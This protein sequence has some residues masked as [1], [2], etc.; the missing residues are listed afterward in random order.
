MEKNT[1]K[2]P[3]PMSICGLQT[4]DETW[5]SSG[6]KAPLFEGLGVLSFPISTK[7]DLAQK[8][9][10]QGLILAYGFNFGEAARSFYYASQLDPDC[11]MC[12]WGYAFV[13]GPNYN[14]R[15][16]A[17]NNEKAFDAV[18]KALELSDKG[19]EKERALINALANRYTK[20]FSEK[21]LELDQGYATAKMK[22]FMRFPHDPDIGTLYADALMNIHPWDLWEKNG[23]PKK[24]TL[25]ILKVL[26]TAIKNSPMHPGAHHLYIHAVEAS[27]NPEIGLESARILDEGIVPAAG[28]LVHMP[29]HIYIHVGEYHKGTLANIKAVA[30]DSAYV[31]NCHAQGVY[32][33]TYY[34]H[35]YHFMAATAT[36]EGN[37]HWAILAAQKVSELT[38]FEIMKQKEWTTLQHYFVI[39][40]YVYVKLGKWDMILQRDQPLDTLT[41]PSA[42]KHYARGLA[43]LGK[44][45][46]KK[47]E[48]ELEKLDKLM[49]LKELK[50]LK[51]WENNSIYS[52]VEIAQRVLRGELFA[53]QNKFT[54]AIIQLKKAVQIE[55]QLSYSEPPDWFFSV[56]HH[57]GAVQIE[58]EKYEDAIQTLEEDLKNFPKNGWALHGLRLAYKNLGE[59]EKAKEMEDKLSMIWSTADIQISSSRIK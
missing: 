56:R 34:P 31:T 4:T 21:R 36:L 45:N 44:G 18:Q 46:L 47:A 53:S 19:N 9:F 24:E 28:H 13:L 15:M 17:E 25:Q 23:T 38:A 50:E 1:E 43:Y 10:N 30:V 52:L 32:P 35:N 29:S 5:Y 51:I 2:E 57:L 22:V 26:K 3:P 40:F 41:Y 14:N 59:T 20:N 55:D 37:S 58:A 39:P 11:A 48:D 49:E 8:Y 6:K 27:K 42:V 7:S 33:L 16:I 12:Y 54:E